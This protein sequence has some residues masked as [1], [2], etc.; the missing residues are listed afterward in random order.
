MTS[1][2]FATVKASLV[3]PIQFMYHCPFC[4]AK[5]RHGS[6]GNMENR[7]EHRTTHCLTK[8]KTIR[9]IIND[10]TKREYK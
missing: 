6:E 10:E 1:L 3:D 2:P 5:H 9:I 8:N 4:N 7:T